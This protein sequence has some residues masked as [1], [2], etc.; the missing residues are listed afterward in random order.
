MG[1]PLLGLPKSIY[2]HL[3][4]QVQL[5]LRNGYVSAHCCDFFEECKIGVSWV[6]AI[7]SYGWL[8]VDPWVVDRIHH[9]LIAPGS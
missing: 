1:A 7:Y 2:Y 8:V 6:R 3:F 4:C 9:T 5:K